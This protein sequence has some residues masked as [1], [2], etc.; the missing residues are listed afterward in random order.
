[1]NS[2][3]YALLSVSNKDGLVELARELIANNYSILASDGTAL[4]LEK[5]GISVKRIEEVT[6]SPELFAGRVKTLHPLIHGAI[7]FDRSD[8]KQVSEAKGAGI[9]NI[10][11]VVVNLYSPEM[12]DIGGPALIRAA[13]KNH[14]S[15]SILTS[16][17][18]YR[19]FLSLLKTGISEEDRKLWARQAIEVTARYDLAILKEFGEPLRYGENPHQVGVLVG[20]AGVASARLIQ[21]RQP[22]FNNYLDLDIASKV[23]SDHSELTFVIVK[24]GMPCGVAIDEDSRLAFTKALASDPVSAFG[25]VIAANHEI[26]EKVAGEI[27]GNFYEAVIAPAFTSDA[28]KILA[29]KP[30]LRV[31]K[32][33][34]RMEPK[35]HLREI[36]GGFLIQSPDT[37]L[38]SEEFNLVAGDALEKEDF[39]DLCFAWITV[40]RARSNAIVIAKNRATIGIGVAQVNR[41]DA[42]R[43]AIRRA[44]EQVHGAVAASDG[45]FPF[46]DGLEALAAS[47]IKA[48]VA[49]SGSIKDNEVIEAAN[50]S[51]IS[52]YFAT[53][54]HFSHG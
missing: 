45:F 24:H 39:A 42:A 15:V 12:F 51:G 23:V 52:L 2:K 22:S 25:G 13:A 53:R 14:Q 30:N 36:D 54:R 38:R 21:G 48:L 11:V 6:G 37:D 19:D 31:L 46:P 26:D 8:P 35:F 20:S 50:K 43:D 10:D 49:P 27:V 44:G 16:P 32:L 9:L 41:L 5:E 47:G 34:V 40:A 17:D 28:L 33:N 29:K 1:M 4:F 7:L 18:Q 3:R